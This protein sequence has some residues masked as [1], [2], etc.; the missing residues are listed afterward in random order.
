MSLFVN[1]INFLNETDVLLG[2]TANR[3][4]L[5]IEVLY[6]IDAVFVSFPVFLFLVDQL[7][8][9]DALTVL[10]KLVVELV[11]NKSVHQASANDVVSFGD[12]VTH[13]PA[14]HEFRDDGLRGLVPIR[15]QFL[16][17]NAV[18]KH[19]GFVLDGSRASTLD[20]FKIALG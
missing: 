18:E 15:L 14:D 19:V 16:V 11:V 2:V 6:I 1:L 5:T 3:R 10:H 20:N 9:L 7:L 12:F 4:H 17:T 13:A 8:L